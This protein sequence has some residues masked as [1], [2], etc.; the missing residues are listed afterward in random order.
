MDNHLSLDIL[1]QAASQIGLN[2]LACTED[3]DATEDLNHLKQWQ[4]KGF[5]GEMSYMDKSAALMTKVSSIFPEA[6]TLI[7]FAV[8]YSYKKREVLK[9]E[10]GF[11][12][13]YAWGLDYHM[14]LSKRLTR[15][16]DL[17]ENQL[18][19]KIKYKSYTDSVPL[20]ERVFAHKAGLG[21]IGKNTML[22]QKGIGSYFL[23]CQL[24]VNF[25]IKKTAFKILSQ[26]PETNFQAECGTCRTCI[27]TCP[28]KAFSEPRILDARKCIS[29]LTIEKKRILS[30]WERKAVGSWVF[31]CDEC[32]SCCPF[33]HKSKKQ[34]RE[35]QIEEFSEVN[36]V[37]QQLSLKSLLEIHSNKAFERRFKN[38]PLLRPRRS[39]LT[40]NALCV[41]VNTNSEA[42]IDLIHARA[43]NDKSETIRSHAVWAFT[44]L[45][46][47]SND[48]FNPRTI[49]LL[50][51][52]LKD[53][54]EIVRAE[55]SSLL[56]IPY[57]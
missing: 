35:H 38:T 13:R 9:P 6:K 33:N 48:Q 43:L 34:N 42:L 17:L 24:V 40:R 54:S 55:A 46:N 15:L 21:F 2:L 31:G 44:K 47:L 49:K 53:R 51:H 45:A 8:H 1:Q 22:I 32:Q 28:T 57:L 18:G 27:D 36:G 56:E 3:L 5:N 4:E 7:S 52:S 10:H 30:E 11:V 41:A 14:F 50:N 12:A 20:L 39:G 37:G 26:I 29:Y 19:F 25:K 23:L 16:V